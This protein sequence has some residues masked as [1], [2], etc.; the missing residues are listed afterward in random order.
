MSDAPRTIR[1][2]Y[3]FSIFFQLLLWVP[4]FYQLQKLS[5]LSDTEIFAIQSVYYVV[6]SFLEI[7]TGYLSDRFGHRTSMLYGSIALVLANA[8]PLVSSSYVGFMTHFLLIASARALIS[9]A[10]SA[11]LFEYLSSLDRAHIYREIEGKARSYS[12]LARVVG[13]G[14]V[15]YLVSL[16]ALLPYS[17]TVVNACIAAIVVYHMPKLVPY[18][19]RQTDAKPIRHRAM[20]W[21]DAVSALRALR[22]SP[23]LLLV[24]IQG[25][26]IFVAMR[27][28][29]VNM[30][31]PL[32]SAR[33]FD[34]ATFG[35]VMAFITIVEAAGNRWTGFV[36]R[37]WQGITTVWLLTIIMVV[38]F[39]ALATASAP[40]TI[41]VL[42]VFSLCVG[43]A[44]PVQIDLLNRHIAHPEYRAT[45]MSIGSIMDRLTCAILLAPMGPM[46][47]SGQHADVLLRSGLLI[48]VVTS[49]PYVILRFRQRSGIAM[50]APLLRREGAS[51]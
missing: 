3:A 2:Y 49:L 25:I 1:K 27:V 26:G 35:T 22:N 32:L 39:L 43:L 47:A 36:A 14:S 29:L 37:R 19:L 31:Q 10:A 16:D 12:L 40:L 48:F 34:V 21:N 30:Y 45:L 38:S 44:A 13:W 6:F 23:D 15:G 41:G 46:I 4:V 5:G 50:A 7:P 33:G 18:G 51:T 11:Y 17:L 24:M 8:A 20:A 42:S 9:G 28:L